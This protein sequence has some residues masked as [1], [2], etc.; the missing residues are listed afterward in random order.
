MEDLLSKMTN[1][2]AMR[3]RLMPEVAMHKWNNQL[4]VFDA[5]REE[6]LLDKLT[7]MAMEFGIAE[8][9]AKQ[10]L[11]GQMDVAKKWQEEMI[12]QWR[13]DHVGVFSNARDLHHEIRPEVAKFSKA[14]LEHVALLISMNIP[15]SQTPPCPADIPEIF[16][17]EAFEALRN[18]VNHGQ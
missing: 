3:L 2:M 4:P 16:W 6:E 5:A 12:S 10:L 9:A 13:H 18:A 7:Q 17:Q 8:E 14:M 1:I 11:Q 15:I